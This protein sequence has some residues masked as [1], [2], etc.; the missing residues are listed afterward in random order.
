MMTYRT[1]SSVR[2]GSSRR[3]PLD[4]DDQFARVFSV[5]G[6]YSYFCGVHPHMTGRIIVK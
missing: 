6:T 5:A 2:R 1:R 3:G 4:T